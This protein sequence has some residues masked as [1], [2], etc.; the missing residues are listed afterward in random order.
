MLMRSLVKRVIAHQRR[1]AGCTVL[2]YLNHF[3]PWLNGIR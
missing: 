3:R 1:D 2:N